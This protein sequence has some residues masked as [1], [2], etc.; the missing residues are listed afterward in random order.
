MLCGAGQWCFV[1]GVCTSCQAIAPACCTTLLVRIGDPGLSKN[2]NP[3]FLG[4]ASHVVLSKLITVIST[5]TLVVLLGDAGCMQNVLS[6]VAST[7]GY[8]LIHVRLVALL[9]RAE[10]PNP[11]AMDVN[12]EED[13]FAGMD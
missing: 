6:G 12:E 8:W 10:A 7:S 3:G 4:C 13:E 1:H 9:L 11:E 2:L 5:L